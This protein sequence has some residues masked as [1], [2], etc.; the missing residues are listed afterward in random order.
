MSNTNWL[1]GNK[2]NTA[3]FIILHL[4]ACYHGN[5]G[6]VSGCHNL[7]NFLSLYKQLG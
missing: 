5:Q 3:R 4:I 6:K 2:G 7:S 1:Q